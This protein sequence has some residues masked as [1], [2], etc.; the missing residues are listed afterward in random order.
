MFLWTVSFYETVHQ[1]SHV[2]IFMLC[3]CAGSTMQARAFRRNVIGFA[4][5]V[6]ISLPFAYFQDAGVLSFVGWRFGDEFEW[7]R[8][9]SAV[10]PS[11]LFMNRNFMGEAAVLAM[12]ACASVR[13]WWVIPPLSALIWYADSKGV[14]LALAA[15][16]ISLLWGKSRL[17]AVAGAIAGCG[18]VVYLSHGDPAL[19]ARLALWGNSLAIILDH[20]FGV[21][22]FWAAYPEYHQAI[23]PSPATVYAE[24]VRPRFAHNDILTL[25][26]EFGI[27]ASLLFAFF[28]YLL[29]GCHV[30]LAFAVLGAFSFPLHLPATVF[31]GAMCAGYHTRGM[32]NLWPFNASGRAPLCG[33][34]EGDGNGRHAGI[35]YLES[36]RDSVP[37]RLPEQRD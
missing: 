14:Y 19:D 32:P 29:R 8:T 12:I 28:L 3:F 11:G 37:V 16:G 21:G 25:G 30:A 7:R 9:V 22:S 35:V 23:L 18:I 17:A 4:W 13:H 1:I 2:A 34:D 31:I 27:P 10:A 36:G 24:G 5:G 15:V 26:V 6:S 33:G 20:P